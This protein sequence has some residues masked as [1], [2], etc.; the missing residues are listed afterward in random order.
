MKPP[1]VKLPGAKRQDFLRE[2]ARASFA[3]TEAAAPKSPTLP[4]TPTVCG[5]GEWL[6][7]IDPK[8]S[9]RNLRKCVTEPPYFSD[10]LCHIVNKVVAKD[11]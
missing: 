11:V 6:F 9:L 7:P 2:E 8:Q 1:K 4:F 3:R 5:G 10:I